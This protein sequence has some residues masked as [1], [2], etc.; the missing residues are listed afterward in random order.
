MCIIAIKP[1]NIEAPSKETFK[2]MFRANPDGAGV[3]F[4]LNNKLYIIKGLMTFDEFWRVCEKIPVES[5]AIYHARISTSGGICQELTH[6]YLLDENIF[7]QRKIYTEVKKGIAVAH[8]G[9]FSEF[10]KKEFNNDTTQFISTY[11]VPLNKLERRAFKSI[12]DD[13]LDK[14]I[15]K[16]CGYSNKLAMID[17]KGNIKKYGSGWIFKKGVYYSNYSFESYYHTN[18]LYDDMDSFCLSKKHKLDA[19]IQYLIENDP[20]FEDAYES[21]KAYMTDEQIYEYYTKGLF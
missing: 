11:L 4:N 12:L 8:N 10:D 1:K 7:N 15:N 13:D 9:V 3:A 17:E 19:K 6:P 21:M 18:F 20:Y 14:I 2:N 5:S 16:L